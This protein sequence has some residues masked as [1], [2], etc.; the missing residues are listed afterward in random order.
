MLY[1]GLH[2]DRD[3]PADAFKFAAR[4]E[5]VEASCLL[6]VEIKSD[7]QEQHTQPR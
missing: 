6:R 5:E 2:D 1:T 3:H 7:T 4:L